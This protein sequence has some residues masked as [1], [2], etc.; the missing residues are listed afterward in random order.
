MKQTQC[1]KH[2][3]SHPD[4]ASQENRVG[5]QN[6]HAAKHTTVDEVAQAAEQG[7]TEALFNLGN[8]YCFGIDV[9]QDKDE[10][11]KWL[12]KAA[13][14]R[15][16]KAQYDLGVAYRIGKGVKQDIAKSVKWYRKA[17]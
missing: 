9:E 7:D 11:I 6:T 4:D 2:G 14:Q 15:H 17:A 13:E 1:E 3:A 16:A 10:A 5:T 8:A 12:R